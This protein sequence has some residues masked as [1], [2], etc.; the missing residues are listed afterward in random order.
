LPEGLRKLVTGKWVSAGLSF[1]AWKLNRDWQKANQ[2]YLRQLEADSRH[3][4]PVGNWS[5]ARHKRQ[6]ATGVT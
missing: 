4:G 2:R 5:P 3:L 6:R 1:Y